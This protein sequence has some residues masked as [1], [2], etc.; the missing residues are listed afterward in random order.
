MNL[1]QEYRSKL[2]TA[3]TTVP[4]PAE[5]A[6][7]TLLWGGKNYWNL[8]FWLAFLITLIVAFIGVRI[9]PLRKIPDSYYPGST[10]NP[11]K[12]IRTGLTMRLDVTWYA[13]PDLDPDQMEVIRQGIEWGLDVSQYADPGYDL[14][15]MDEIRQ[16]LIEGLDVSPYARQDYGWHQ[17]AEIRKGI[18]T[19]L[20]ISVYADPDIPAGLMAAIREC[21][22]NGY[23]V[24]RDPDADMT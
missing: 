16:G 24:I 14:D 10:P 7:N 13:G 6:R 11:E 23:R 15:Q 3:D 1:M 17:M 4:R 2:C 18:E 9:F 21:R 5:T 12:I 8:Y 19:G 20:D 22:E